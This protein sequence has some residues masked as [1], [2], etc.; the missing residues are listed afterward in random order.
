MFELIYELCNKNQWFTCGT[1]RQYE[2]TLDFARDLQPDSIGL[3]ENVHKL[4]VMIWIC[5]D[6]NFTENEIFSTIF[7]AIGEACGFIEGDLNE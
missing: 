5:S 4:A 7:T 2:K 6:D 1:N 3:R